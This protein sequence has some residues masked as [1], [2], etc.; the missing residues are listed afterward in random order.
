[1]NSVTYYAIYLI[2]IFITY[3]YMIVITY[4][5][6]QAKITYN[7][8]NIMIIL[9][10]LVIMILIDFTNI[11]IFKQIS[12]MCL[13]ILIIYKTTSLSL[14]ESIR[15][16]LHEFLIIIATEIILGIIFGLFLNIKNMNNQMFLLTKML[17]TIVLILVN[18]I[19]L[20]ILNNRKRN[21][22]INV[23]LIF[24]ILIVLLIFVLGTLNFLTIINSYYNLYFLFIILLLFIIF[25]F[26][27]LIKELIKNCEEKQEINDLK[28]K[29][30]EVVHYLNELRLFKHNLKYDLLLI[31]EVGNN[32]TNDIIDK[33]L[34]SNNKDIHYIDN[35]NEI[36]S[37]L[38]HIFSNILTITNDKNFSV[39][40]NNNLENKDI[41]I[42]RSN[43]LILYEMIGNI[44]TNA[45]EATPDNGIICINFYEDDKKQYIDIINNYENDIDMELIGCINYSTKN[46]GS[47][48]GL[49]SIFNNKIKVKA[50][51]INDL[52]SI[53][54]VIPKKC[55]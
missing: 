23:P 54:V 18:N 14:K 46:R 39:I 10:L 26:F 37:S 31:K 45:V 38:V 35:F 52:F 12:I 8:K 44:L 43:Y 17:S 49:H 53:T 20:L 11:I 5:I 6:S 34:D 22:K 42:N 50:S 9:S 3:S 28:I 51:I 13:F 29:N 48:F 36:P 25:G 40:I 55:K 24:L 15:A 7:I 41:K 33:L 2:S 4:H 16:Y 30:D 19:I 47:G 21:H 27:I 1:M 32:K